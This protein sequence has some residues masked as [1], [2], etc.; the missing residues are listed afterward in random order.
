MKEE[1]DV[2]PLKDTSRNNNNNDNNSPNDNNKKVDEDTTHANNIN[3][4]KT[5]V[6]ETTKGNKVTIPAK[7][8][9]YHQ[10]ASPLYMK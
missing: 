2:I 7:N 5:T 9:M 4:N 1:K 8:N 6:K 3:I 10:R